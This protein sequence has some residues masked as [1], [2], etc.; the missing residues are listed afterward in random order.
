[1]NN[2]FFSNG[3]LHLIH[4]KLQQDL[5]VLEYLLTEDASDKKEENNENGCTGILRQIFEVSFIDR[6]SYY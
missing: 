5:V 3:F 2:A 1:M 6:M 4:L